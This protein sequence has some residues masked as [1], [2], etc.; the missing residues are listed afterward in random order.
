MQTEKVEG[1]KD[2]IL[3]TFNGVQLT[4]ADLVKNHGVILVP[5]LLHPKLLSKNQ[6]NVVG[7]SAFF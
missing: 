6:I 4:L 7:K 1:L 3:P 5:M 2:I